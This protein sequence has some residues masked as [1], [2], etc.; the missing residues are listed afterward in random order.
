MGAGNA[1]AASVPHGDDVDP[2]TRTNI[3]N[4]MQGEAL[5]HVT[6]RAYARQADRENLPDVAALY[7][8]TA[9]TELREH[10]TEQAKLIGL[11]GDNTANLRDSTGGESYEATTMYKQFA[12]QAKADGDQEAARLFS[13]VGQDEA[14]HRANFVQA[15]N[16]ITERSSR[17]TVPTDVQAKPVEIQAG[18]PRVSSS[19]TL[20]NL[21]AAMK[22][23]AFAYAKYTLYGDRAGETGQP[24]LAELFHRTAAVERTEH[25]AEHANMAGAVRDTGTNL[26]ATIKGETHEGTQMYPDYARQA[27]A[28]GD[29]EAA[30]VLNDTAKDELKHAKAFSEQVSKLGKQCPM[31]S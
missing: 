20:D 31:S 2:S 4:A 29:T 6:Y 23:E 22:G 9:H 10:F 17:A 30:R 21:R 19:R 15:R 12:E 28:A 24:R 27:S 25:F 7:R 1:K 16:A 14:R 3:T 18:P 8:R 5:A 13:E 11:A 26:C